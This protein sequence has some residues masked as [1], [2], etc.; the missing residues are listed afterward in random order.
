MELVSAQSVW[1]QILGQ[2][3]EGLK[4][5]QGWCLSAHGRGWVIFGVGAVLLV[6]GL[7]PDMAG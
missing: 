7:Y 3:D 2:L 5:C 6:G 4:V 1:G